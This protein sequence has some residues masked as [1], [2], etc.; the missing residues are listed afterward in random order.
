[1]ALIGQRRLDRLYPYTLVAPILLLLTVV[2]LVPILHAGYTSFFRYTIGEPMEFIGLR[3]YRVMLTDS[4]FWSSVWRTLVFTA[5]SLL[6]QYLVGL[7]L[8][9]LL[10]KGF[11]FQRLWLALLV[12]PAAI[13]SVVAA[14]IWRYML[15][16][17]GVVNYALTLFGVEPVRWLT[18]PFF[19]FVTVV[20]VMVWR[21][22]PEIM[23]ILYAS[24]ISM[25]QEIFDAAEVDGATPWQTFRSLTFPLLIPA[26]LVA[27]SF[28]LIFTF[29][30]FALPWLLTRGGPTG[31]TNF[32]SIHMYRQAFNYWHSGY[33][34]AIAWAIMLLTLVLSITYLRL[35]YTHMFREEG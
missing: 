9:L 19:A 7:G 29:R 14:V 33:G 5:S 21:F 17:D 26:T 30:E 10:A 27:M 2:I 35:M 25:P 12:S 6:L 34:S 8:A 20:V 3:N 22:Y 1:M 18:D 24:R 4:G 13:S 32:L 23:L 16:Y 31:A 28:R 11:R 15:G